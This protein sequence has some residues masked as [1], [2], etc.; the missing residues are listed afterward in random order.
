MIFIPEIKKI[1]YLPKDYNKLKDVMTSIQR[2]NIASSKIFEDTQGPEIEEVY[3]CPCGNITLK[4]KS[5]ITDVN[6]PERGNIEIIDMQSKSDGCV[7]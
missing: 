4:Q 3:N 6:H 5:I 2:C 7:L 1:F